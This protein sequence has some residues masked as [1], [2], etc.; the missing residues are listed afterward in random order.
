MKRTWNLVAA[1][2]LGLVLAGGAGYI[3]GSRAGMAA[4]QPVVLDAQTSKT[5]IVIRRDIQLLT[6]MRQKQYADLVKDAELWTVLQLQQIDAPRI[7]EG[8]SSDHLYAQTLQMV[9]AYRKEFPDTII[10]PERDPSIAKAF[11]RSP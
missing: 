8:S 11:A 4:M 6:E 2:T 9:N 1:I 7:L 3:A 10:N 5:L